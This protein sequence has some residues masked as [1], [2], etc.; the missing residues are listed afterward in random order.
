MNPEKT[1]KPG[2]NQL[3]GRPDANGPNGRKLPDR[4]RQ[5]REREA[6]SQPLTQAEGLGMENLR[7]SNATT[8][9]AGNQSETSTSRSGQYR[10]RGR[11]RLS[12]PPNGSGGSKIPSSKQAFATSAEATAHDYTPVFC[13]Q[14]GIEPA[15][16]TRPVFGGQARV[17]ST[18]PI[19]PIFGPQAGIAPARPISHA[20]GSQA[21]VSRAESER[22]LGLFLEASAGEPS[23]SA[24]PPESEYEDEEDATDRTA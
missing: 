18:S 3:R 13:S 22:Y 19:V 8:N 2:G 21:G 6:Q 5:Q 9:R 1:N 16:Y 17:E 4:I 10:R 14:A 12:L 15:S 7:I 11:D 20:F 24:T 23:A